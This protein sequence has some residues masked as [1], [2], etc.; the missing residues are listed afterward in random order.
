[1]GEEVSVGEWKVQVPVKLD[2]ATVAE[3]DKHVAAFAP[4][5]EG[6]SALI[7]VLVEVALGAI[8]DGTLTWD[9]ETIQRFLNSRHLNKQR[10]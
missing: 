4:F 7:R 2:A 5:C 1:M 3:I 6:R 10:E 8:N 9:L